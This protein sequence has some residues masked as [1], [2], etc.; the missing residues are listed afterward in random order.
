VTTDPDRKPDI[1]AG[2]LLTHP[3]A[4]RMYRTAVPVP[5]WRLKEYRP[6]MADPRTR[7]LMRAEPELAAWL[8]RLDGR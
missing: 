2:V 3:Q 5:L 8:E 7:E 6:D 4:H 1:P